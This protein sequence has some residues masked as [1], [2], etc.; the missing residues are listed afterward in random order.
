[1]WRA[2]KRGEYRAEEL[3]VLLANR[4]LMNRVFKARYNKFINH[5]WQMYPVGL[6][7]GLGF[8]TATQVGALG[9]AAGAAAGGSLL[10]LAIISL[11]I[12]FAAGM[13]MMDT[14]ARVSGLV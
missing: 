9:L 12:L 5:S 8:D 4:G 3:D 14:L 7:F 13:S 11:P 1:M 2:A 6:L 10:P